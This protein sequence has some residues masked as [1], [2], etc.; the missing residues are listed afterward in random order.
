MEQQNGNSGNS[1]EV[2]IM[3]TDDYVE[4]RVAIGTLQ[5]DVR[6]NTRTLGEVRNLL[7]QQN[8]RVRRNEEALASIEEWK[9][10]T[11]NSLYEIKC[12]IDG[13][14]LKVDAIQATQA[15]QSGTIAWIR[16]NGPIV[17]GALLIVLYELGLFDLIVELL[18]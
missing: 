17:I 16:K 5:S 15:R 7:Q 14:D 10:N 8:G 2:K 6:A 12:V 11:N 9:A 1:Q 4:M 18:T 13:L 3:E